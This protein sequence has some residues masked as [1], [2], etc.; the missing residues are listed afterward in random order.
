VALQFNTRKSINHD[1]VGA[2]LEHRLASGARLHGTVWAGTRDVRQYLGFAGTGALSAGGVVD[3]DRQFGGGALRLQR[4]AELGGRP[5]KLAVGLE[6][7]RMVERRRGYANL[8]GVSGALKRD[9]DNMVS[10][11][12]VFAQGEW[13][14]AQ[15]WSAHAGVRATDGNITAGPDQRD[16]RDRQCARDRGGWRRWW[17]RQCGRDQSHLSWPAEQYFHRQPVNRAGEAGL[18]RRCC[19]LLAV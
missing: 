15:R 10:S 4:E 9:E 1:Q 3:L 19:Q 7:E 14:F 16:R 13:K 12:G 5:L 18:Q 8:N 11:T 17:Q 6:Y 2:A